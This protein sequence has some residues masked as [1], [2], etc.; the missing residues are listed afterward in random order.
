MIKFTGMTLAEIKPSDYEFV[1]MYSEFKPLS[2]YIEI[3]IKKYDC[4]SIRSHHSYETLQTID[5]IVFVIHDTRSTL[6]NINEKFN[7]HYIRFVKDDLNM[8]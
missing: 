8:K 6:P 3:H 4:K 1:V 2:Q 7:K 5:G